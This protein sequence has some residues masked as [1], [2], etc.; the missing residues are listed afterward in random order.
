[1]AEALPQLAEH[2]APDICA[3]LG[4]K[5]A[6]AQEHCLQDTDAGYV[7]AAGD[8]SKTDTLFDT[9]SIRTERNNAANCA[10]FPSDIHAT[11]DIPM[12]LVSPVGLEPTTLALK[13]PCSTD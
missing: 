7:K 9:S 4:I 3:R 6:I 11:R 13:V 12:N 10:P 8:D 1:M 2:P 5:A